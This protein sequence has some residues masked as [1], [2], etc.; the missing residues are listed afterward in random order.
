M[1]KIRF[2]I[3]TFFVFVLFTTITNAQ[4]S[5][6]NR[7]KVAP[8][9]FPN[10]EMGKVKADIADV[11]QKQSDW[12]HD[13]KNNKYGKPKDYIVFDDRIE[14]ELKN[15]KNIINFSD[16]FDVKIELIKNLRKDDGSVVNYSLDLGNYNIYFKTHFEP[17]KQI[18]DDMFF[19][20][21]KEREKQFSSQLDLFEPIAAQYHT[22]KVKPPVS[23]EQRKYVVQANSFNQQKNYDKAIELYKKAIETDQVAYPAAYSNVA[24]L[25]AQTNKFRDAIVSMKKYLMLEPEGSD[26]RSA[27]DKIYEWEAEITK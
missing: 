12:I 13:K 21:Q 24:L 7:E 9:Y 17:V 27:Q 22:L 11:L 3:F 14:F 18:T 23:E 19:I 5:K 8:Q 16:L 10:K 2:K 4:E 26:A 6:W 25:F 15:Q 20:Q 1:K